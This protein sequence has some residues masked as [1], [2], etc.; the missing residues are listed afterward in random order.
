[1]NNLEPLIQSAKRHFRQVCATH[2]HSPHPAVPLG[3][4]CPAM[5][6]LRDLLTLLQ[7]RHD[8][9][10]TQLAP[11]IRRILNEQ[12]FIDE[13]GDGIM[14]EHAR[15]DTERQ[16]RLTVDV[17]ERVRLEALEHGVWSIQTVAP[18]TQQCAG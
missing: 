17:L 10:A 18:M 1:M 5:W 4:A 7:E 9:P 6:M 12:T 13:N 8:Q 14:D 2:G 15:L 16:V 11:H 3:E